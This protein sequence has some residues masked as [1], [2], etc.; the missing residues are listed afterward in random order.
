MTKLH[1]GAPE[2]NKGAILEVLARVLPAGAEVL[3]I[4]S[5]SG[6]HAAHFAARL[7]TVSWTPSDVDP[8]NLASIR[9]WVA[10]AQLPNLCEPRSID[11]LADDWGVGSVD[12]VFNANMV[13]ITPWECAEALFAGA[14]RHVKPGGL[15]L[16][17]GP[18][19]IGGRAT[20]PSNAGF[21]ADLRRRDARFGVRD[22]ETVLELG[23]RSGF[24]F[25]ER[26]PMPA[27]NQTLVFRKRSHGASRGAG[28]P[29]GPAM[30]Y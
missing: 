10:E 2:R 12:A 8:A 30:V 7:P 15:L 1:W 13:H 5:G 6:Q 19:H 21:D 23:A 27:N 24:D 17:Y 4:A 14:A 3:E 20:A 16:L 26:V 11:V 29:S 25:V 28:G 22:L 18:F 9:A